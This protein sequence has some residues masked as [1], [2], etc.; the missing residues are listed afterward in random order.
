[1]SS[2]KTKLP[3]ILFPFFIPVIPKLGSLSVI[4]AKAGI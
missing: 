1:M 4:P 2:L 3:T